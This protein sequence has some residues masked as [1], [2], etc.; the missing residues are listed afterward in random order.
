MKNFWI[1]RRNDILIRL[2]FL[3]C[4][5]TFH[6][7]LH[8]IELQTKTMVFIRITKSNRKTPTV[9]FIPKGFSARWG[10]V[11]AGL[12]L[13]IK[14]LANAMSYHICCDGQC[15]R[16]H[17]IHL[18]HLLPHFMESDGRHLQ[19][20]TSFAISQWIQYAKRAAVHTHSGSC[21]L[22]IFYFAYST[23]RLSRMTLT[24]IWPG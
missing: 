18:Y 13:F 5:L 23:A 6:L 22:P 15:K 1:S 16:K 17:C 24:L 4:G 2:L 12:E 14:P 21:C 7:K 9:P 19:N 8:I 11:L 3:V 20:T 10:L